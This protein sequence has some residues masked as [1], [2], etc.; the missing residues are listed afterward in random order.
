MTKQMALKLAKMELELA[1]EAAARA[2][3]S[4]REYAILARESEKNHLKRAARYTQLAE[5]KE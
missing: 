4:I 3:V 2:A 5:Q 1:A